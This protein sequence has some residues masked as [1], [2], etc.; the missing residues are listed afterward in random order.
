[1]TEPPPAPPPDPT[2][3]SPHPTRRLPPAYYRGSAPV[4]PQQPAF[5]PVTAI[6]AYTD[7]PRRRS[8]ALTVGIVITSVV[9]LLCGLCGVAGYLVSR[10]ASGGQEAKPPAPTRTAAPT[11]SPT[12]AGHHIVY[13]VSGDQG[14][15]V[16]TYAT[17][18]GAK[19]D[20]V[21]LPWRK[22]ITVDRDTFVAMVFA[23]HFQGGPLTCRVLVDG[24][25]I[26]KNTS[27]H[28]VTCTRL[29]VR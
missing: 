12:T 19:P 16:V 7:P 8:T 27:D 4:A 28:A 29:V 22:E 14:T 15:T 10:H 13:E 2:S 17:S 23:L 1:M 20:E 11:P 9:I 5:E 21:S 6:P 3:E 25:E 18:G 26:T 24:E